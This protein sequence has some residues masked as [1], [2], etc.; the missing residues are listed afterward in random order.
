M[1]QRQTY[2]LMAA[3]SVSNSVPSYSVGVEAVETE[4]R[5]RY[6]DNKKRNADIYVE[7]GAIS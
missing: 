4:Q 3:P 1:N 2:Q 6:E 5:A 7:T